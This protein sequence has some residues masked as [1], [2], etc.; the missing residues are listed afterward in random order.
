MQALLDRIDALE[1]RVK[2]LEAERV[3]P[4]ATDGASAPAAAATQVTPVAAPS[5][6]K[7]IATPYADSLKSLRIRGLLQVDSR[8]FFNNE[9]PNNDAF[10]IRRARFYL[11]GQ[12]NRFAD[13]ILVPDFA[14]SAFTLLDA[15]LNFAFDKSFQLRVGRFKPPVGLEYI[16]SDSWAFFAERSMVTNF[17]PFRDLGVLASGDLL[18]GRLNY[19]FGV[20]NGVGDNASVSSTGDYDNE[21]DIQGRVFTSPFR[22]DKNSALAGLG[23]GIG[24]TFGKQAGASALTAGYR[25]DGQQIFFKYRNAAPGGIVQDGEVWRL[26]PQADFYQ[27]P[28]G[29]MAEYM[30]STVNVRPSANAPRIEVQNRAWQL[31]GGFVLTGDDASFNGIVPRHPFSFQDG[32]WGALELTGRISK[33]D[34]DDNAFPLLADPATS[35]SAAT[36]WGVGMNWYPNKSI[37]ASIDYFH[38][39]FDLGAA[40]PTNPIIERDENAL[41]TRLQ[42]NF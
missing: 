22:L 34:I 6:A 36:S 17:V 38:T 2:E 7:V 26:S 23:F 40:A 12:L 9:V 31:S 4:R 11:E 18:D 5:S 28:F 20:M 29:A 35:A 10:V 30:I 41:L 14:G 21:K 32:T 25:T 37:R 3:A 24:G 42:L 1:H 16:Q 8:W 33:L 39:T 27:G 19:S 13:F 15:N